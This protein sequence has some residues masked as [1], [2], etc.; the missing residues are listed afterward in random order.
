MSKKSRW[1]NRRRRAISDL[2][3]GV[4][5]ASLSDVIRHTR[6]VLNWS[7]VDVLVV[8]SY[9]ILELVCTTHAVDI[10]APT[11]SHTVARLFI[12]HLLYLQS[13]VCPT[14]VVLCSD[15]ASPY[16]LRRGTKIDN[17]NSESYLRQ[18]DEWKGNATGERPYQNADRRLGQMFSTGSM[19]YQRIHSMVLDMVQ[20]SSEDASEPSLIYLPH[21]ETGSWETKAHSILTIMQNEV[22]CTGTVGNAEYK[23]WKEAQDECSL[24]PSRDSIRGISSNPPQLRVLILDSSCEFAMRSLLNPTADALMVFRFN[25]KVSF[26]GDLPQS[27]NVNSMLSLRDM[28]SKIGDGMST[29]GFVLYLYMMMGSQVSPPARGSFFTALDTLPACDR[30]TKETEA[31]AGL[32]EGWE[33]VR[34]H[35][36]SFATRGVVT[37]SD[38]NSYLTCVDA[39]VDR[40]SNRALGIGGDLWS[41]VANGVYVR[42]P[43]GERETSAR[44]S[45]YWTSLMW[46][47]CFLGW[48]P[49]LSHMDGY[50]YTDGTNRL[51]E[52]EPSVRELAECS[53]LLNFS[54]TGEIFVNIMNC[55]EHPSGSTSSKSPVSVDNFGK[56]RR[57]TPESIQ[58]FGTMREDMTLLDLQYMTTSVAGVSNAYP[59]PTD[60][61]VQMEGLLMSDQFVSL[62]AV[63][64]GEITRRD[65]EHPALLRPLQLLAE[66][67]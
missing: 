62:D 26:S 22:D 4:E 43:H 54:S 24:M 42:M 45:R 38:L 46:N 13:T 57:N 20:N 32:A 10:A 25:E 56:L 2:F 31:I 6:D 67:S 51:E 36:I 47:L 40:V 7:K 28:A 12:E 8:N 65:V 16:A 58:N 35:C 59:D 50:C 34:S 29:T 3:G 52:G 21:Y 18:G 61:Y 44:C 14:N 53:E 9:H 63:T 37:S 5:A 55:Y 1:E 17:C 66:C 19:L 39:A 23:Q 49:M 41:G 15:G 11:G 30:V 33:L 27:R 64:R 60:A 48:K